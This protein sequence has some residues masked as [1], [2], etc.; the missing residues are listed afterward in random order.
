MLLLSIAFLSG[1]FTSA[2][3]GIKISNMFYEAV[4]ADIVDTFS[5]IAK[6]DTL[7]CRS[8]EEC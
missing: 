4:K 2:D 1:K 6:N 8:K 7:S 3:L 5:R